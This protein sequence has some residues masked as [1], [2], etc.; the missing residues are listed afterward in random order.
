MY[1]FNSNY[2]PVNYQAQ[3]EQLQRLQQAQQAYQQALQQ[4]QS[5]AQPEPAQPSNQS[6]IN[7]YS[8]ES[9]SEAENYPVNE[10]SLVILL[11]RDGSA[12]YAKRHDKSN[13]K[14]E[15]SVYCKIETAEAIDTLK[16]GGAFPLVELQQDVKE[17]KALLI[18]IADT[19]LPKPKSGKAKKAESEES[20]D[21]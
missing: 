20:E 15:F 12:I 8:V 10:G 19:K 16:A 13:W 5:T 6:S 11:Q 7:V 14:T 17:M 21:V 18:D 3:I 1:P 9:Q 4:P 2:Q